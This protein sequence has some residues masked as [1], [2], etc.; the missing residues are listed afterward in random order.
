MTLKITIFITNSVN[1]NA[2]SQQE[3]LG[4]S[5]NPGLSAWSLHISE[6]LRG[7]SAVTL[8]SFQRH[9]VEGKLANINRP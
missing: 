3:G 6:G 9:D 4:F 7:F 2:A 1:S 5:N 8:A